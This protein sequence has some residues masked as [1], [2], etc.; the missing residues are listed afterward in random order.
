VKKRDEVELFSIVPF[1]SGL[2]AL[3]LFLA[4]IQ[5]SQTGI[6]KDFKGKDSADRDNVLDFLLPFA[7]DI[8]WPGRLC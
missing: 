5:G 3:F 4:A 8:S 2:H 6:S 7:F 1:G